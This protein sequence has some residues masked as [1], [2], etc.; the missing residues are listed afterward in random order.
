MH[1]FRLWVGKLTGSSLIDKRVGDNAGSFINGEFFDTSI[2]VPGN[3]SPLGLSAATTIGLAIASHFVPSNSGLADPAGISATVSVGA[4]VSKGRALRVISSGITSTI[5]SGSSVSSGRG[6]GLPIGFSSV[7]SLG[8]VEAIGIGGAGNATP[9]GTLSVIIVGSPVGKGRGIKVVSASSP[10]SLSIGSIAA[11]G[12]GMGVVSGR[13]IITAKDSDIARGKATKVVFGVAATT[14][15][16]LLVEQP[17]IV[18][19]YSAGNYLVS[20]V[21]SPPVVTGRG[22]VVITGVFTGG[23]SANPIISGITQ[24]VYFDSRR[25]ISKIV[26]T[27]TQ[28]V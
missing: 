21:G 11:T 8:L 6:K 18:Y 17:S 7:S 4:S 15:L 9:S 28:E 1:I 23:G 22:R 14:S 16:G 26:K 2:S 13:S 3:A 20:S 27:I 10:S 5:S 19:A 12:K 24:K 25:R